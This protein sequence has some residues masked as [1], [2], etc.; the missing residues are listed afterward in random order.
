MVPTGTPITSAA[1]A[2][3]FGAS[4]STVSIVLRGDAERRKILPVTVERVLR[5]RPQIYY[6]PNLMASP[7]AGSGARSCRWSS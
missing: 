3:K 2:A 1:L 5:G 4:R 7:S 6:V